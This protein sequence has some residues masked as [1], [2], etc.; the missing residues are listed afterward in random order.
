MTFNELAEWY[1][2]LEKVKALAS[3]SRVELSLRKFNSEFGDL[4]VSKIKPVDLENY[5]AKRKAEGLADNTIVVIWGDHGWHLGD[6]LVWG[7]HTLFDR[8]L[9][10]ALIIKVPESG[11]PGRTIATIVETVD[12]YPTLLKLCNIPNPVKTDGESFAELLVDP[13]IKKKNVAYSY[14]RKGIT[15]R[16]NRYRLTKYYRDE[17]PFIELYDYMEDPY[18]TKNL[19]S[20]K[21]G[22]VKE[23]M[24]LLE[25]GNTGIYEI[26]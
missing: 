9:K 10:S 7:K 3:Y 8:S 20:E 24:P 15:L 2:S 4:I 11:N 6:Q 22:I 16:T 26:N 23:L 19:A 1:L 13:S 14:F 18:E 12:L 21:P 17:M 25:K 5:Q